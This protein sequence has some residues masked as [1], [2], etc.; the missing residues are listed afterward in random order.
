MRQLMDKPDAQLN[1]KLQ[2]LMQWLFCEPNPIAVNT[3]LM[4][5][6]AV[7]PVFRLPYQAL[8]I[9]QRQTGFPRW[10][11]SSHWNASMPSRLTN[12]K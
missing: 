1:E 10:K 7:K 4:M 12:R 11:K 5:T 6:K 2:E 8:N 9:Q 3:T